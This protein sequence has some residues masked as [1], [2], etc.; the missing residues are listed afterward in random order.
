VGSIPII[1]IESCSNEEEEEH[2]RDVLFSF[3]KTE[4]DKDGKRN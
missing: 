2:R 3:D 4:R 1:R